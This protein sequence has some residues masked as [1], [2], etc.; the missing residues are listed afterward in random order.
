[1]GQH[2][3]YAYLS[4]VLFT[5]KIEPVR[6]NIPL[7]AKAAILR[8][9]E[10]TWRWYGPGDPV[11]LD[12]VLQAGATGIVTALHHIPIGQ[13]W[14]I[15]EI[16][17]R[18]AEIEEKG[19][20]WSVIESLP[21]HEDVKLRNGSFRRYLENY[22]TSLRNIAEC[23]LDT[24][25]YNFMPV[26]DWTRTQL[27]MPCPDGSTALSFDFTELAIFDLHILERE[28]A[29]SDYP[30]SVK[31]EAAIRFGAMNSEQK[32]KLTHTITCGL[33]GT[34]QHFRFESFQNAHARYATVSKQE[35]RDNLIA[36]LEEIIPIASE[37]HI[38]MAIHPDDPPFD[39]FGLPRVASTQDDYDHILK[40]VDDWHNGI[41]LCTG[42]LGSRA[43]NDIIDFIQTFGNRI[44][45]VHLRNVTLSGDRSF[46]EDN[47]L[48]GHVNMFQVLQNLLEMNPG[49]KPDRPLPFRPDHGHRMLDDLKKDGNPGYTAIGRLRG[50][51]ELRGLELGIRSWKEANTEKV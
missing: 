9:L 28:N 31:K 46:Y 1:V 45:F 41:T 3:H 48:D 11:G 39:I 37:C 7:I 8:K 47:H 26:L 33:P 22:K 30:L 6:T 12:S 19:L 42:S 25:C 34:D 36:F 21:L 18:I 13:V 17:K 49:P 24:V 5:R 10:E 15:P 2:H 4:Q 29:S 43:D 14:T 27:D 50:L 35:Y 38:Q 20:T 23:G 16:R 44:H 32:E 40:Q 51:A